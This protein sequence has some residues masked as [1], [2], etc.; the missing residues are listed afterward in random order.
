MSINDLQNINNIR[1]THHYI[2]VNTPST[3]KQLSQE[4]NF[5]DMESNNKQG[6]FLL[7]PGSNQYDDEQSAKNKQNQFFY[8]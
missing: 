5:F 6:E 1:Q 7:F 3:D 2:Q 8:M 4:Q